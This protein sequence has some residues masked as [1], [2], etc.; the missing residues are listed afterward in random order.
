MV[1]LLAATDISSDMMYPT[2]VK[3]PLECKFCYL[4]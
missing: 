3:L 2:A 1:S 4:G